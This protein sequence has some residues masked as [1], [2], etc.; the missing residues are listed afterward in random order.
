MMNAS[1]TGAAAP[2]RPFFTL[3]LHNAAALRGA[4]GSLIREIDKGLRVLATCVC[5]TIG[6]M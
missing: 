5:F 3:Q 6:A 4:F 1:A 2:P